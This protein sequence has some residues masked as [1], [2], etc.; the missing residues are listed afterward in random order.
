MCG[1]TVGTLWAGDRLGTALLVGIL[2]V[3]AVG[4]WEDIRGVR[5]GERLLLTSVASALLFGAVAIQGTAF[6][7]LILGVITIPWTLAVVNAMNFMD[8]INGISA[9]TTIVGGTAYALIGHFAGVDG[10]VVL[11]GT[12]AAA[13][14][15]FAPFNVP[16]A[17][18][19]L[20]DVGSYGLGAAFAAMSL[21]ALAEGVPI[22][23]AVAPLA[24]YLTDTG[25]TIIARLRAGQSVVMP[26]KV[27]VYQRLV[28]LGASH[29]RVSVGVG[30]LT[31]VCA[32]LGAVSVA[33]DVPARI[34][35]NTL[36]AALLVAYLGSPRLLA[37][38][39]SRRT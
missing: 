23:A 10:L 5:I 35:A 6:P 20:G 13:S 25:S 28:A 26:H 8:G 2:A 12:V 3:A 9:A 16:R 33:G 11:G 32:S 34:L 37:A 4:A 36:L 1:V 18:V 17:R 21:L 24:L 14:L 22:E 39:R 29:T 38:A 15:G 27:H 19:F 31:G 7:L 30:L